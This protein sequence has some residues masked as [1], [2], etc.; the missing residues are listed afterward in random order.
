[1]ATK[2]KSVRKSTKRRGLS[3]TKT[4]HARAFLSAGRKARHMAKLANDSLRYGDCANAF[5]SLN[6]ATG[7]SGQ[8]YAEQYHGHTASV[9]GAGYRRLRSRLAQTERRFLNVCV[10]NVE[11]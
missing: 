6:A 7:F 4:E 11:R 3:G 9:R 10:T 8:A 1:M 2:K 5:H